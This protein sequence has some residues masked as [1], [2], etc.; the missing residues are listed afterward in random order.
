[1]TAKT[2]NHNRW[3]TIA[4]WGARIIGSLASTYW[5]FAMIAGGLAELD[6]NA[7]PPAPEGAVLFGLVVVS[8][9]G[10]LLAWRREKIGGLIVLAG[11]VA[12]SA[13]AYVT[14]SRYKLF[15]ILV[16]GA[17]FLVAGALF[18]VSGRRSSQDDQE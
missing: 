17:P 9:L 1:M 6:S 12:L 16:S 11:G 18:V 2:P 7:E 15:A 3:T 5:T 14:A 8:T 10:V 13:F 4:R